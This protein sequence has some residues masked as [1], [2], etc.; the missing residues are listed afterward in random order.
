[1]LARRLTT[2]LPAM[3][4][5]EAVETTRLHHVAGLTSDRTA[6]VTISSFCVNLCRVLRIEH[7]IESTCASFYAASS[8][9]ASRSPLCRS[10]HL[11]SPMSSHPATVQRDGPR[12]SGERARRHRSCQGHPPATLLTPHV[13]V[14]RV[15]PTGHDAAASVAAGA[16]ENAD[17]DGDDVPALAPSCHD[18]PPDAPPFSPEAAT[19]HAQLGLPT[20]RNVVTVPLAV[21]PTRDPTARVSPLQIVTNRLSL[22]KFV[23][24]LHS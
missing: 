12:L 1:M 22:F 17:D 6:L 14:T 21:L 7:L 24:C 4:L 11:R 23:R 19:P 5:A 8:L 13:H 16:E 2:L 9:P 3:T 15:A 18:V 10:T 20:G